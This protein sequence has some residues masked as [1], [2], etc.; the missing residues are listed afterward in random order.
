VESSE[1]ERAT[2]GNRLNIHNLLFFT[3]KKKCIFETGL[4]EE[5]SRRHNCTTDIKITVVRI[6]P[7]DGCS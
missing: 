2:T 6:Y 7:T 4:R 1:A 5:T 3:E